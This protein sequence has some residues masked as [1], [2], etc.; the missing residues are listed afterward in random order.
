LAGRIGCLVR[1]VGNLSGE[2][3]YGNERDSDV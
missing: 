2:I 3:K 1:L